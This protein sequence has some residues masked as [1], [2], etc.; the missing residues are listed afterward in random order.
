MVKIHKRKLKI[1]KYHIPQTIM[2]EYNKTVIVY[3]WY[4]AD[5]K[6]YY[7]QYN[8]KIYYFKSLDDVKR[9]MI[10]HMKCKCINLIK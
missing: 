5:S 8:N 4:N 6:K 1:I 10:K 9:Y 2:I 3:M 7:K